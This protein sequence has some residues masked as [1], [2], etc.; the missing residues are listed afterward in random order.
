MEQ[1]LTDRVEAAH[2]AA[3]ARMIR[4]TTLQIKFE[5]IHHIRKGSNEACSTATK[6]QKDDLTKEMARV[7]TSDHFLST[8][9]YSLVTV[10][11][12]VSSI[13]FRC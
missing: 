7:K 6:A 4:G 3:Q 8:A 2:K 11:V 10:L 1:N 9:A 12:P 13:F 5:N